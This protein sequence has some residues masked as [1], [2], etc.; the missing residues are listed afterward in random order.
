MD[1]EFFNILDKV[2]EE[3]VLKAL[4]LVLNPPIRVYSLDDVF[5]K[6]TP[7]M[8][9]QPAIEYIEVDKLR[10]SLGSRGLE[11][12]LALDQIVSLL[13]YSLIRRLRESGAPR[14]LVETVRGWGDRIIENL[15][16]LSK[17]KPGEFKSEDE[18]KEEVLLVIPSRAQVENVRGN[19][20]FWIWKERTRDGVESPDFTGLVSEITSIGGT[21]ANLGLRVS[22]AV[23]SSTYDLVGSSLHRYNVVVLDMPVDKLKLVYVR[24]QSVTWFSNPIMGNMALPI[25]RGEEEVVNEI[26][27]KLN[28]PP[29][30]RVRWARFNGVLVRAVMEGGNFFVIRGDNGDVVILTGIGVR[31]SN[32]AT[33][34]ILGELLPEDVRVIGVPLAGYV[35]YWEYGAVHLDVVF[36]Y[37]GD[38]GGVRVALIDPSRLGF[39]SLLEYDRRSDSFK[40]IELP[41]LAK[42][43]GITLDEPPREGASLITI[44]N[45]LNLGRGRLV[46]DSYN[47]SVNK[48][49]EKTYGVEVFRVYIPHLEAG[50]GGVRCA[51]REL[52]RN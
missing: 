9:L 20:S 4:T 41:R 12:F 25:R 38:L 16:V 40:L 34:K 26:Y 17:L 7:K 14:D 49:L 29:L 2:S 21:L 3:T 11:L 43:L 13:P 33:F 8:P 37:I 24:D 1:E 27:Y 50:G 35:K 18:V 45:A 47:E 39:Y 31:G 48:Y 5:I 19:Q 42:E 30:F 15:G 51:T 52:W 32:W 36:S 28:L 23:D 6:I 10:Q 22:V 46:V 44:V